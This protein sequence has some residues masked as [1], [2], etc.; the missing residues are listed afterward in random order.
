MDA[1][2]LLVEDEPIAC[3]AVRSFLESEGFTVETVMSGRAA[4]HVLESGSYNAVV[5]NLELG[6]G[7]DGLKVLDR[8]ERVSP[9]KC[10]ILI[11]GSSVLQ[12]SCDSVG[13]VLLPKPIDLN[14]LA[15]MLRT[16]LANDP[17]GTDR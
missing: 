12:S 11:S 4:L 7:I 3:L 8:F 14:R 17:Q 5:T 13:A 9:G 6:D 16:A 1:P 2:I 15:H 10:K